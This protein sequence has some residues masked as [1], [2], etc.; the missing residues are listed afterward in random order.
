MNDLVAEILRFN[1]FDV[2]GVYSGEDAL[3]ACRDRRPDAIVLDLM[4]PGISG[5]EV[6]HQLKCARQTNPVPVIIL[7]A[8]DRRDDRV[9]GIRVG[10][11]AYV[12]KPFDP[13]AL[14]EKIV[15]TMDRVRRRAASGVR[16]HM[17]V[18]FE[19]EAEY[20]DRVNDLLGGLL[21]S[22]P[23]PEEDVQQI[24]YCLL[25]IGKKAADWGRRH[26]RQVVV[27]IEYTLAEDALTLRIRESARPAAERKAAPTASEAATTPQSVPGTTA[28]GAPSECDPSF[29]RDN[30]G[31]EEGQF[32]A[33]LSRNFMDDICRSA[34]GTEVTLVKRLKKS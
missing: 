13:E 27:E 34:D 5:Y 24:R 33:L 1:G 18:C 29:V 11:D 26:G 10:A 12:T 7:T 23:L 3:E 14:V 22:S 8:L 31:L 20:L 19:G 16:G 30:L 6:C 15:E 28:A 32:D 21:A 25:E 4:L 9:R 2:R 17:V